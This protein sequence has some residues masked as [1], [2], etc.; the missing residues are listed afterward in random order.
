MPIPR[1]TGWKPIPLAYEV[2]MCGGMAQ[3][4]GEGTVR[5]GL[6]DPLTAVQVPHRCAGRRWSADGDWSV[7]RE[8]VVVGHEHGQLAVQAHAAQLDLL[9]TALQP[10]YRLAV[11]EDVFHGRGDVQRFC[12][13]LE[14]RG[15]EMAVPVIGDPARAVGRGLQY[16]VARVPGIVVA[17]A[18]GR[19]P[20]DDVVGLHARPI[21]G[22][23]LSDRPLV[24]PHAAICSGQYAVGELPQIAAG[25]PVVRRR[26]GLHPL[27]RGQVL[28]LHKRLP[29]SR[30]AQRV[31]R[32]V[33]S[34]TD[35]SG[36]H[37]AAQQPSDRNKQM[38]HDHA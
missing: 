33:L 26:L 3:R 14:M 22:H 37:A 10:G 7:R 20:R 29:I 35:G 24:A 23:A 30:S 9:V 1:P 21:G 11:H 8:A 27:A 25:V 31:D 18:A 4:D 5:A 2:Q 13:V 28:R 16:H 12:V 32:P 6:A 15:V 19:Q 17:V 36:Q 38:R 34:R